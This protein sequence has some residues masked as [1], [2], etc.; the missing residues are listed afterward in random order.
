MH[1][2]AHTRTHAH[3]HQH[4]SLS[5]PLL[6]IISYQNF[7]CHQR[8]L[9]NFISTL[10]LSSPFFLVDTHRHSHRHTQTL[11]HTDTRRPGHMVSGRWL[12]QRVNGRGCR[13][14]TRTDTDIDRQTETD[15]DRHRH[16][17]SQQGYSWPFTRTSRSL[18]VRY[19]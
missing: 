14:Q 3:T 8:F 1:T 6:G 18:S 11:T 7:G 9:D 15:T 10:W 13:R 17:Q 5:S 19:S 2:H 4:E 12:G 16:T